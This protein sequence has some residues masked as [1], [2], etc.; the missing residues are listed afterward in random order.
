MEADFGP[1]AEFLSDRPVRFEHQG[2]GFWIVSSG[3]QIVAVLRDKCAHM[4][5][6][7]QLT[8]QGFVCPTHRWKF[9]LDGTNIVSTNGDVAALAYQVADDRLIVTLPSLVN[10][11]ADDGSVLNG[12][13][14]L[15]L[16][17]HASFLLHSGDTRLLFDPWL[18]GDTYWGS[19]RHW[20]RS[21]ATQEVM[22][23]VSHIVV[24][25]PHP[26]H[27]HLPTFERLPRDA[28]VFFP[29]FLSQIIPRELEKL[30]FRELHEIGWEQSVTVDDGIAFAFL[31]PTSL[32]ED[33]AVLVRVRDWLWLNQ[34]DAGA[35]FRDDLVPRTVD[36]LSSAFDVG[37]TD[38]P[39]MWGVEE[40][41]QAS[42]LRASSQQILR[43]LDERCRTTGAGFFAPFASW[44]RHA[45]PEHQE[46]AADLPHN[47]LDDVESAIR[48][49]GTKLLRTEPGTSIHL[50]SMTLTSGEESRLDTAR[51]FREDTVKRCG[52]REDA[53]LSA[54]LRD[55]LLSLANSPLASTVERVDFRVRVDGLESEAFAKF[56]GASDDE[57]IQLTAQISR[58]TAERLLSDDLTV[59]WDHLSVGWWVRWSRSPDV[60]P[61]R[62]MR[63]LQLGVVENPA[64]SMSGLGE[65]R[66]SVVLDT[67]LAE[68]I[69]AGPAVVPR[70][71]ERAGLPCV[72]CAA[73][74]RETL[75]DALSLHGVGE[76]ERDSLLLD[77]EALISD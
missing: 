73:V 38:Y 2:I 55:R 69:E 72:S 66:R 59:T 65:T 64:A 3:G 31:R 71:L 8:G 17:A 9:N 63:L 68:L 4:G 25:H 14:R 35:P 61:A 49:S 33:S 54:K 36:L 75:R 21:V 77:L 67:S 1:V 30:G 11:L 40:A 56:G 13:E 48:D 37:A 44:W 74:P 76:R 42:L 41:K 18:I 26:D 34:N 62:F 39:Q 47:S 58:E 52:S 46:M 27:F 19:W 60:Y 43:T 70:I 53:V 16:L 10:I 5:S 23:T 20:P 6:R 50:K 51:E 15:D 7:L 29:P 12:D 28:H 24:S 32:W 22:S 45:L 57:C